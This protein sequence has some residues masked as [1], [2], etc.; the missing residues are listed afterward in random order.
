MLISYFVLFSTLSEQYQRVMDQIAF[1]ERVAAEPY[2]DTRR[3]V[4]AFGSFWR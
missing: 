1:I 2:F 4:V 3:M